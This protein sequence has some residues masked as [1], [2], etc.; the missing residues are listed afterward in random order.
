MRLAGDGEVVTLKFEVTPTDIGTRQFI[1]KVVPPE[2]DLEQR[3]NLKT[4]RV[5]IVER[6]SHVLLMAGGPCREYQFLRNQLFRDRDITLDVLLQSGSAG[7]SQEAATILTEFPE[8]ADDL[9]PYDCIVAF[10]PDWLKL[11]ELQMELLDRWVAEQA[12][13]LIVVAGP[14]FTPQWAG[15]RRGRDPRIDTIKTLYPVIFFSQGSPNL[16][17]GRFGGEAAWPLNFTRDGLDAEF[18]WLEDDAHRQRSGL[19][20]V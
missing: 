10:D 8:S 13:G 15:L 19:A 9:F 11:D 5:K 16:S 7:A 18:L 2:Q 12:G 1:L 17:L 20:V 6:K 14:V 4:A 3:D